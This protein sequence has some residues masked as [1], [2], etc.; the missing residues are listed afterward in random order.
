MQHIPILLVL[1]TFSLP[2]SVLAQAAS[3]E[4]LATITTVARLNGV[5]LQCGYFE[6]VQRIK[7][8]LIRVLPKKRALGQWFEQG[9]NESFTAFMQQQRRCPS[10]AE[11]DNDLDQ[12]LLQLESV[13]R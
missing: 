2:T 4:Q 8:E 9:T 1:L 13:F 5:A 3:E 11:L 7:L 12:A 10:A 6:E